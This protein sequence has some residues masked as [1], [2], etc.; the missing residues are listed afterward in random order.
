MVNG[1]G[2]RTI[3]AAAP[4]ERRDDGPICPVVVAEDS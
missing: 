1:E 2:Y 4:G 3:F